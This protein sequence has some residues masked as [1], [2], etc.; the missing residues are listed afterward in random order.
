MENNESAIARSISVED[1]E[2]HK[3]VDDLELYGDPGIASRNAPVPKW[4]LFVNFS[5]VALGLLWLFLFWNGSYGWLDRGY[6]SELQR[7]ANTTYP[8]T[9]TE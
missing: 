6:W 1:K 7:A 5:C 9:T 2:L 8:Y 4:L 3:E